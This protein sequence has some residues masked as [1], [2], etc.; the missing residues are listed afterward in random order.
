MFESAVMDGAPIFSL[1]RGPLPLADLP[2]STVKGSL[3][4]GGNDV[5]VT[6]DTRA[7]PLW[8]STSN[9]CTRAP[10]GDSPV[11]VNWILLLTS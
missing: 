4:L 7:K 1:F 6:P 2:A 8:R 3:A 11:S 10:A 9:D 5:R